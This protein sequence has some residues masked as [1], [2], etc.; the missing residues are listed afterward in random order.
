MKQRHSSPLYGAF[1]CLLFVMVLS[2]GC[3]TAW[4]PPPPSDKQTVERDPLSYGAVTSKVRKGDT[5][6]EEIIRL[7]GAPNITTTNSDGK[8]VWVYDRISSASESHGWSEARRFSAFFGLETFSGKAGGG[9]ATSTRTLTVII[10]FAPDK[11][12]EDYTARA[13]QF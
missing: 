13:T 9:R 4:Q 5:T 12:V 8:E 11:C 6:Q 3:S 7:F 10:T 1:A 2:T